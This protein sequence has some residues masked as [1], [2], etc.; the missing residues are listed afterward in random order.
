MVL[1]ARKV[2]DDMLCVRP[3]KAFELPEWVDILEGDGRQFD[4]GEK[5]GGGE[6]QEG[7]KRAQH[8]YR[9]SGGSTLSLSLP[10]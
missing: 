3:D 8:R 9:L 6:C 5:V 4:D 7:L 2:I 1:S 10:C